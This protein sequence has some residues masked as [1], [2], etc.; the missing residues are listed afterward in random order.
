MTRG[1]GQRRRRRPRCAESSERAELEDEI[2]GYKNEI[3][4]LT[5]ELA[6]VRAEHAAKTAEIKAADERIERAVAHHAARVRKAEGDADE[7]VAK[8]ERDARERARERE[9]A[10]NAAADAAAVARAR[11]AIA[12]VDERTRAAEKKFADFEREHAVK[13]GKMERSRGKRSAAGG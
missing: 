2:R 4:T 3:V 6:P 13:A 10:E 12:E 11:R 8:I 1:E 7:R 5:A 9:D